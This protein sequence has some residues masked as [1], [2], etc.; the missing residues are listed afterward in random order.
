MSCDMIISGVLLNSGKASF[1]GRIASHDGC[2]ADD[3]LKEHLLATGK[4]KGTG[5]S[6]GVGPTTWERKKQEENERPSSLVLKR[7]FQGRRHFGTRPFPVSL[8]LWD[9]TD[10]CLVHSHFSSVLSSPFP[11]HPFPPFFS[12]SSP[13]LS[14]SSPVR[15][16]TPPFPS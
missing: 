13:P 14:P 9:T 1:A 8:T 6:R 3:S 11:P 2:F 12:H 16:P 7:F 15:S 10:K 5:L 4:S